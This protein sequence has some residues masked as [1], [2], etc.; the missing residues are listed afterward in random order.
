MLDRLRNTRPTLDADRLKEQAADV[1][2]RL[3]DASVRAAEAADV[4]AHQAKVA[5]EKAREWAAPRAQKAWE[6]G[7]K[8]AAPKIEAA[9]ASAIPLV[10]RGHDKLVDEILPKLVAAVETAAAATASGAD[11]AR[12]VAD[13]KL[14]EIAHLAPPPR[15][16]T[17]AKVF[18]SIAGLAIAAGVLAVLRRRRPA[19][20]PWAEEPWEEAE[21]DLAART[22]EARATIDEVPAPE[23]SAEAVA[24][25]AAETAET[26]QTSADDAAPEARPRRSRARST[27][28]ET[29]EATDAAPEAPAE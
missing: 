21:A 20:D 26:A 14:T 25:A 13:A 23:A 18:W 2:A 4:L 10:D 17:G 15:R 28:D 7:R 11:R 6:E 9:A 8:A 22:A 1:G 3:S 24:E 12:E 27:A 29:A 5:A 16:R 19:D